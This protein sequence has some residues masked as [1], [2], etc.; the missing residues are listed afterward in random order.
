MFAEYSHLK[1]NRLINFHSFA[2]FTGK[3]KKKKKGI[4]SKGKSLKNKLGE[5]SLENKNNSV[6]FSSSQP[7]TS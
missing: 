4:V 6:I 1:T 7:Y 3:E 5:K 2:F